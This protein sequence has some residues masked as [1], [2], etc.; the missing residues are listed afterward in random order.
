MRQTSEQ[1]MDAMIKDNMQPNTGGAIADHEKMEK[2]IDEKLD[3]FWKKFQEEVASII[4]N[5]SDAPKQPE[6]NENVD[7]VDNNVDNMEGDSNE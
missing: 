3:G 1:F 7:N 4:P 2:I 6:E 5:V